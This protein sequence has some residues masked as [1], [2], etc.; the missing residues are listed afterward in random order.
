MQ[1]KSK[2]GPRLGKTENRQK[3]IQYLENLKQ[4]LPS[5]LQGARTAMANARKNL[6]DLFSNMG[7]GVAQLIAYQT[8]LPQTITV[9]YV[10]PIIDE[11]RGIVGIEDVVEQREIKGTLETTY[12]QEPS[13][14]LANILAP[15]KVT[16][17]GRTKPVSVYNMHKVVEYGIKVA[18]WAYYNI[19]KKTPGPF[20]FPPSRDLLEMSLSEAAQLMTREDD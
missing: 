7:Y 18:I 10:K 2:I 14:A 20:T 4:N 9:R 11:N 12:V 3:V 8:S 6:D 17:S 19:G 13:K 16:V 5:R 1:N 15:I